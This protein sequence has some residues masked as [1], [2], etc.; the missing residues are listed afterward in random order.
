MANLPL[1]KEPPKLFAVIEMLSV[2]GGNCGCICPIHAESVQCMVGTTRKNDITL[3]SFLASGGKKMFWVSL[4]LLHIR[5]QMLSSQA[6]EEQTQINGS[7][8]KGK[9][10]D[11]YESCNSKYL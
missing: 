3:R 8:G 1:N 9:A 2:S 7:C 4:G 5:C 11:I 6:S 10:I